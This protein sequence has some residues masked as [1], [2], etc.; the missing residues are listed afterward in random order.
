MLIKIAKLGVTMQGKDVPVDTEMELDDR[1]ANSLIDS[2]HAVAVEPANN[3]GAE[4]AP[5]SDEKVTQVQT[6]AADPVNVTGGQAD[7]KTPEEIAAEERAKI[8]KAL[9]AQYKRDELVEKAKAVSV[10]F[11]YDAKKADIIAA[12]IDQGKATALLK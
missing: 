5:G 1:N 11:A 6:P 3:S 12:V 2:G 4:N 9:D 7:A 8:E 10:E